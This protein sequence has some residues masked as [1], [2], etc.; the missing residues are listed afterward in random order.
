MSICGGCPYP[1]EAKLAGEWDSEDEF[2]SD[3][4]SFE[5]A[6]Y[7]ISWAYDQLYARYQAEV[8]KNKKFEDDGK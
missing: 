3:G 5:D 7:R 6:A 2:C 1:R 4:C 8:A